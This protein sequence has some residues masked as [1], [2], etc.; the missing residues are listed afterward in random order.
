MR[1]RNFL[2]LLTAALLAQ[3]AMAA[4]PYPAVN[5]AGIQPE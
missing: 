3:H 5:A 4:A 1:M 2:L